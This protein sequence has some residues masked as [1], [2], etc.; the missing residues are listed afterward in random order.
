MLLLK[1]MV[2]ASLAALVHA[3]TAFDVA[4]VKDLGSAGGRFSMSGGPGTTDPGRIKYNN[5]P[6]R[7]VMLAAYD[8]RNYQLIGPAWLDTERYDITATFPESTPRE[9]L[10]SMLRGLIESRFRMSLHWESKEMA[11]Y[12]LLVAKKGIQISPVEAQLPEGEI[13]VPIG[14]G[15]DGFPKLSLPSPGLV[16]ETKD[17]VARI[18]GK[19]VNM[20]KFADM[21]TVQ[22]GRPVID[23]TGLPGVYSFN[24][25][26]T[27]DGSK[28][29]DSTEP[30]L[31]AAI[32]QQ[33]GL[34]LEA[35]RRPVELL[36]IDH[37]EK[38]PAEN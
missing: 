33:L 12:A 5:V 13:A 9:Q 11:I 23:N 14:V 21:L 27:P 36:V 32:A 25:Y 22:A 6:L 18:T 35:R 28:A 38:I 1:H 16:I 34:A 30:D 7:R 15:R 31:F 20:S 19:E 4:S 29:A 2:V 24:L 3:Q 10:Q 8:V 37:A 17:G 26:F